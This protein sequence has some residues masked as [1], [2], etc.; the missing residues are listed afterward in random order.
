[1]APAR[2]D[3]LHSDIS[4]CPTT[5][6][7][8]LAMG[9]STVSW[10]I[11]PRIGKQS[12]TLSWARSVNT[13]TS[14]TTNE[15][16]R[17]YISS[18]ISVVCSAGGSTAASCL[19]DVHALVEM[20]SRLDFAKHHTDCWVNPGATL[21]CKV[22]FPVYAACASAFL[23]ESAMNIIGLLTEVSVVGE[24]VGQPFSLKAVFGPTILTPVTRTTLLGAACRRRA[25]TCGMS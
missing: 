19:S 3:D 6:L 12:I 25:G 24:S 20:Q 1:M 23:T 17:C 8:E 21:L 9:I 11:A 10:N 13:L 16:M 2:A 4:G 15:S 18:G 5:V 7:P 14:T 22:R